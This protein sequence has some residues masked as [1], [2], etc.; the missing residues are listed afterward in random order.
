MK[1]QDALRCRRVDS[2]REAAKANAAQ[3]QFLDRLVSA[4]RFAPEFRGLQDRPYERAVSARKRSSPEGETAQNRTFIGFIGECKPSSSSCGATAS[5]PTMSQLP[6]GGAGG[7]EGEDRRVDCLIDEE[8]TR[9]S[10]FRQF[11][12][13]RTKLGMAKRERASAPQVEI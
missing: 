13:S 12:S 4:L 9:G 11:R 7:G 6:T 10:W 1:H 8:S 5:L 2:L 3:S